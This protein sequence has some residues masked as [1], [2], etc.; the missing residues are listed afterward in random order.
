[1]KKQFVFIALSCLLAACG[2]NS[3][4][5][6]QPDKNAPKITVAATDLATTKDVVC[7]MVV[8]ADAIA[9]TALVNGKVYPFCNT[10]CKNVFEK[11]KQKYVIN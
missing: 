5:A 4:T 10:A 8:K 7:G 1:M 11:D 9:D 3:H 2:G 6:M